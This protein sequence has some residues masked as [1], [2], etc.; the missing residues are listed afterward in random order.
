[1][2]RKNSDAYGRELWGYYRFK[3][4]FEIVERSDGYFGEPG[5]AS[6]YFSEFKDWDPLEKQATIICSTRD[7]YHTDDKCHLDYHKR[8]RK[9]GR[10]GGQIRI[11]IRYERYTSDWFDYLFVSKNELTSILKDSGWKVAKYLEI[12]NNPSYYAILKKE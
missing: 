1:M 9:Q 11:R 3:K 8:N 2:I 12:R 4:D 6:I 7:P 5:I 10:M